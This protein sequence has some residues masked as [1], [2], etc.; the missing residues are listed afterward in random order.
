ME[1]IAKIVAEYYQVEYYKLFTASRKRNLVK[2]RQVSIY[3]ARKA[4]PFSYSE[5]GGFFF[6]DHST[7]IH[8]VKTITNELFT[9]PTFRKEMFALEMVLSKAG[10]KMDL[11]KL[12]PKMKYCNFTT[13]GTPERKSC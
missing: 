4:T 2:T 10:I 12:C 3:V 11:H 6:R 13:Y 8:S 5:L 9:N 7:S 1:K